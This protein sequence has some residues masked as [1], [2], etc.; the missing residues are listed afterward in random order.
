MMK[1]TAGVPCFLLMCKM[2]KLMSWTE[3]PQRGS[4]RDRPISHA[5]RFRSRP[6]RQRIE[7]SEEGLLP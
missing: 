2:G 7:N 3:V 1:L 4:E 5:L 6:R